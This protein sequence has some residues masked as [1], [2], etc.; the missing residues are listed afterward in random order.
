MGEGRERG[1]R[2]E[3]RGGEVKLTLVYV[4]YLNSPIL[5]ACIHIP[6][7]TQPHS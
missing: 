6:A 5:M 3:G 1:G 2:G 7:Y 4:L